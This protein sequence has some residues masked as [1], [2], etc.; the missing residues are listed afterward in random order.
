MWPIG[1][2]LAQRPPLVCA[3]AIVKGEAPFI[4]EWIAYHRIIGVDHFFLYDN[5]ADSPLR[6]LLAPH[7][8]YLTVVDG[9]GEAEHLPGRN[10]QTKA[11][12]DALSRIRHEWVAFLDIDEFIVLRRHQAF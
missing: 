6:A 5:D 4:D 1:S 3:V 12:Q 9:P 8:D 10:K 2:R 7:A 11:Y